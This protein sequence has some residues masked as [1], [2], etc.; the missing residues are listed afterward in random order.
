[1]KK[2]LKNY[3]FVPPQITADNYVLGAFTDKQILMPTGHGW[4]EYLPDYEP[5]AESY[6]TYG[7]TAWGTENAIE[8]LDRFLFSKQSN[9]SDRFV[10]NLAE[11]TPPG[12]D[13]HKVAE[14]IRKNGLVEQRDLPIPATYQ[15]FVTPRPMA[16]KYLK[17]GAKWKAQFTLVHEWLWWGTPTLKKR[18]ELLK[19]AL[20]YSPVGVSVYAWAK[21]GDLYVSKGE[22]NHWCV[23]FD[24]N[25]QGWLIFDSY[26]QSIKTLSF[27]HNIRYAKAYYLKGQVAEELFWMEKVL[28]LIAQIIPFIPKKKI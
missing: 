3:G 26:D 2:P 9:Y 20:K 22:P 25:E 18:A 13:P 27:E 11:I 7:C 16:E 21:E 28:K 15:E 1:M 24:W 4:G 8:I 10:Y 5:Q 14:V 17:L 19:E 6:E 12:A 23:L